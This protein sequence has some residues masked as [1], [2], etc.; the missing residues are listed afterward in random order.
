M[1]Y[2]RSRSR[3]SSRSSRGGQRRYGSYRRA[4]STKRR[5]SG[6]RRASSRRNNQVVRLVIEQAPASAI[7]RPNVVGEEARPGRKAMF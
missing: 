4:S 2:R 5:S 1:A 3:T 6:V 7:A